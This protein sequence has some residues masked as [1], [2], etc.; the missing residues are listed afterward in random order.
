MRRRE[1]IALVG[2]A[3]AWPVS[4]RA[5]QTAMPV[6]GFLGAANPT[7]YSAQL[8]ALR[9]GL[10]EHGYI[11]GRNIAI[12]YRWAE[13]K[14][15]RLQTLAAELVDLN[16]RLIITQGTPAALA[17]KQATT[18]IPIVMA[19]VGNP[20]ETGIVASLARPGGNI[21]GSS[22]FHPELNA[23]R[24]ELMKNMMPVLARAG[25]LINADNPAM[26]S[27][28]RFMENSA[29]ALN[30]ELQSLEVRLVEDVNAA[31]ENTK[32]RIEALVVIDE[33]LFIAH[34]S[35][36]AE[37]ALANRLPSIGFR[38]YCEAGGLVAYGVDFPYIWR[39]SMAL[40]DKI[41]KGSMPADL[42]VEQATRFELMINVKT[43]NTL[44]IAVPPTLLA[45]A[46][47]VIE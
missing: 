1:V 24:L 34:A 37:L 25:V 7:G 38:A 39:R 45:R 20:V 21:T 4:L 36:I 29:Q 30:I 13:G 6:I 15:D 32:G 47:E 46:D 10:Q 26:V 19:I 23:K 35:R 2:G 41:L 5:Q 11:E 17:A 43:A 42:P 14:Y 3:A 9:L 28:L 16:V 22:F 40:V 27:L 33:G 18:T 31:F 8:A 44:G 12:E